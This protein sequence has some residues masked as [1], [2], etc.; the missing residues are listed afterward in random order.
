LARLAAAEQRDARAHLRD[1]AALGRDQAAHARNVAAA[2]QHTTNA[3]EQGVLADQDRQDAA[4]DREQAARDRLHSHGDRELLARQLVI[5]EIDPLTGARARAAGLTDLERELE[6]CRRT[7]SRLVVVY[8]DIVGLKR[9][10]DTEGHGAGDELLKRVVGL[11]RAHLR[12]YDLIIRLG[13]DEF[14]CVMFNTPLSDAR[15]RFAVVASVLAGAREG[16]AIRTG[17]GAL[18]SDE[19]AAELIERADGE[20]TESRRG[21]P[22]VPASRTA[23]RDRSEGS[24]AATLSLTCGGGV[25]APVRARAA[26][27]ALVGDV[28]PD[29]LAL[30]QLLISELVTN[31]VVHGGAGCTQQITMQVTIGGNTVHGEVRD[32]GPG[33]LPA[34]SPVPRELGGLGLVIVDRSANRWGTTHEGRRVWFEMDGD[35]PDAPESAVLLNVA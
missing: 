31:S 24:G 27:R 5:A 9:V 35:D 21:R 23:H 18:T 32:S 7:S 14:L 19:T 34:D 26:L 12:S 22:V 28:D 8:V 30:L 1:L 6:R 2:R 3:L 4:R 13:G 29:R 33:F 16:G 17:F 25:L 15:E 10:N 11:I 20:L